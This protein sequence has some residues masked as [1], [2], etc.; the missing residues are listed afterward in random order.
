MAAFTIVRIADFISLGSGSGDIAQT[1]ICNLIHIDIICKQIK[2]ANRSETIESTV[3]NAY[4]VGVLPKKLHI[5]RAAI[6]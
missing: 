1:R 6:K 4:I 2:L 3:C 5:H